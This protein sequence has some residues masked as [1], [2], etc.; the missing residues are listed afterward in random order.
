MR[1]VFQMGG[2]SP[3][4]GRIGNV[5]QGSH[6]SAPS[7]SHDLLGVVDASRPSLLANKVS[8]A[9]SN[10]REREIVE[11]DESVVGTVLFNDL[12]I[13]QRSLAVVVAINE[14]KAPLKRFTRFSREKGCLLDE[15]RNG[16]GRESRN[17]IHVL[18]DTS[19]AESVNH[20]QEDAWVK[21]ELGLDDVELNAGQGEVYRGPSDVRTDLEASLAFE[22]ESQIVQNVSLV[23]AQKATK[24][25][26]GIDIPRVSDVLAEEWV[27][28]GAVDDDKRGWVRKRRVSGLE[29]G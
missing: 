12:R 2:K 20:G 27:G 18:L 28:N 9:L 4:K 5:L 11:E 23:T 6:V 10:I 29:C 21:G 1:N 15:S 22:L 25:E 8:P 16:S 7:N 13:I 24:W 3:V 19:T 14:D 17:E 26:I